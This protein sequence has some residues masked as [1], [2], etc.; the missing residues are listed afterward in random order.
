MKKHKSFSGFHR[1]G[2]VGQ[3]YLKD[4]LLKNMKFHKGDLYFDKFLLRCGYG[5]KEQE[6]FRRWMKKH[7][8]YSGLQREGFVGQLY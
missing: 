2:Y 7:K 1:E 4:G 6:T 5:I 3:L 8:S